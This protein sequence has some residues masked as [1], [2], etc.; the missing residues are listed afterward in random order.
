MNQSLNRLG[1]VSQDQ[2][3]FFLKAFFLYFGTSNVWKIASRHLL[4]I[5]ITRFFHKNRNH[6]IAR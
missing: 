4:T 2:K 3:H 5:Y 6:R 1:E